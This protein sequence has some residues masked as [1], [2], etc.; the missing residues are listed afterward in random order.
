M[1]TFYKGEVT[2]VALAIANSTP[3]T[4]YVGTMDSGV[5][6]SNDGV[7]WLKTNEGLSEN[8]GSRMRVDAL[9]VDPA[10]PAR[11]YV[12]TTYLFG[13]TEVHESPVGVAISEDAGQKWTMMHALPAMAVSNLFPVSGKSEAVYAFFANSRTPFALGNAE[14]LVAIDTSAPAASWQQW[15]AG[16]TLWQVLIVLMT[17]LA[18]IV[19]LLVIQRNRVRQEQVASK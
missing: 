5:L 11:L 6:K 19:V 18:A 13:S 8:P 17:S 16:I 9:A 7:L 10:N 1:S 14:Q 2:D 3:A 15:F 12:A 4:V